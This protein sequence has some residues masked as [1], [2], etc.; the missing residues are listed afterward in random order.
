M[1][2]CDELIDNPR[3][4]KRSNVLTFEAL[5]H[6]GRRLIL[7]WLKRAWDMRDCA[8]DDTFEPFIYAWIAFNGW[9]ACVTGLDRD[10]AWLDALMLDQALI[11]RFDSLVADKQAELG[12]HAKSFRKTWPIFK[13]QELRRASLVGVSEHFEDREKLVSQYLSAK[14]AHEPRCWMRHHID[15]SPIPLDWCHTLSVLYRVRCNLF[16]GEKMPHSEIDRTILSRA[17]RVLVTFL[18]ESGFM[19]RDWLAYDA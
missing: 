18:S 3:L 10:R 8:D 13:A 17:F 19:G 11:D 5:H 9:A 6:H 12:R 7:S 4:A 16:H 1:H 2:V 15:G 14:I